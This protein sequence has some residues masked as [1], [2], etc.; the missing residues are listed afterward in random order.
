LAELKVIIVMPAFNVAG[1][2]AKTVSSIPSGCFDEI[3]VVDDG[4]SDNTSDVAR[5]LGATVI[6][7]PLN[8]GYGAAQKTGYKEAVKKGADIVVLVHGDNQYDPS[9]VPAFVSKIAGDG[10]GLVTGTRMV[11]GDVLKK[12]MPV[13]KFIPNRFLTALENLVFASRISDYHNGFRAYSGKFLRQV[14]LDLLSD[15][16]DFD[17]DIIVQGIIRGYKIGEI[18]HP[19]RYTQENSQMPFSKGVVYGLSVLRTVFL[20]TLHKTGIYKQTIFTLN[21][22][23]S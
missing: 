14:P 9:F 3:L 12:G 10:C 16:F 23:N 11:L 20:Y 5:L 21:E 13:W 8:K 19:T 17:T 6:S 18:P 22:K 2:L 4:S 7:H 15:K 1:V